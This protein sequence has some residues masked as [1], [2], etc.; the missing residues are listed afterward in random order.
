CRRSA[1]K[2]SGF[3]LFGRRN[4]DLN[5]RLCG[6]A[7]MTSSQTLVPFEVRIAVDRRA[8]SA[9]ATSFSLRRKYGDV[10]FNARIVAIATRCLGEPPADPD[11][12]VRFR[13]PALGLALAE[14]KSVVDR[15]PDVPDEEL[16]AAVCTAELAA[17]QGHKGGLWG[18][19]LAHRL[20]FITGN[21]DAQV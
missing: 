7:L 16:Y 21:P 15:G 13:P 3:Q 17:A 4:P 9:R 6:G 10:I 19:D 18:I 2:N 11:F 12:P 8:S 14:L 5:L 1:I 20:Q